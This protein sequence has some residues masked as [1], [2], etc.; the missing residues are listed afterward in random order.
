M[1]GNGFE[2]VEDIL[3]PSD[4]IRPRAGRR[5]AILLLKERAQLLNHLR[6]QRFHHERVSG[7]RAVRVRK[8]PSAWRAA[9][10]IGSVRCEEVVEL[11]MR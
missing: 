2:E 11:A 5:P 4:E 10:A 9:S 1:A 8:R 6:L 7:A 3:P